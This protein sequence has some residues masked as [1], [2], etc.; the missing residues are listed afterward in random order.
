MASILNYTQLYLVTG[1]LIIAAALWAFTQN[2]T[3]RNLDTAAQK[4]DF[5]EKI[6]A[7]LFPDFHGRGPAADFHRLFSVSAGEKI[8]LFGS[9]SDPPVCHQQ[10]H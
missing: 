2:P 1:V 6:L 3:D 10:H 9:G 8:R 7:V 5:P 4:D